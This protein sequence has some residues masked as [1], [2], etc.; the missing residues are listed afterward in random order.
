MLTRCAYTPLLLSYADPEAVQSPLRT[1]L[2]FTGHAGRG[3]SAKHALKLQRLELASD[4][5]K[6]GKH[7]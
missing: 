6:L 2:R 7:P 5:F 3:V 1:R 4:L